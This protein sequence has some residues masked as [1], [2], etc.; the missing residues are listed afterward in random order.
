MPK[1]EVEQYETW[2]R[3]CTVEADT[4]AQAIVKVRNGAADV[5]EG[6]ATYLEAAEDLGQSLDVLEVSPTELK[7][8]GLQENISWD[9]FLP[10]ICSVREL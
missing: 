1:F 4:R 10:T 3:R 8:A 9:D 5:Q 7:E 6:K 2:V